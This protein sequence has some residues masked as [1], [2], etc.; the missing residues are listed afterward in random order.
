MDWKAVNYYPAMVQAGRVVAILAGAF[1]VSVVLNRF[2]QG[3]RVYFVRRARG[4]DGRAVVELEKQ[5]ATIAGILRKTASVLVYS[6]A[7]VMAL[8][9]LGFDVAPLIAGA[10]VL[11]LA[12]GFG[13][14]NLVRDVIAGFFLLAENQIR[15][16]DVVV[17]NDT[18]GT[19]EEINLRTTVLRDLEGAV[20][21]IPNGSITKLAN[22]TQVFSYY[23][24]NLNISYRD[25]TD[26]VLGLLR[27]VALEVAAEE[28]Y[29][30]E[31][32]EPLEILGVDQLGETSVNLKARIKTMPGKQ[33]EVGREINRRVRPRFQAAGMDFPVKGPRKVEL[34]TNSWTREELRAVV[35]DVLEEEKGKNG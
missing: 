3:V 10:G 7:I 35:V 31:V 28:P 16:N 8:R 1:L 11:G 32:L 12:I 14:Q 2:I 9:E 17:I 4:R 30:S 5:A 26:M 23:V 13:A 20:H 24:F 34:L 33:W 27:E 19:V 6:F 22:R 29:K 25:D 18:P 15:V 21:V